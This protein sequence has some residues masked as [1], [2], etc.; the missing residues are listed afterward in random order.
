[1]AQIIAAILGSQLVLWVV[2][3]FVTRHYRKKDNNDLVKTTLSVLTYNRLADKIE[4][5]LT[6]GYATPDERREIKLLEDVYKS[7]G[8]NGDMESRL[9]KVYALRTNAPR[10]KGGEKHDEKMVEGCRRESYKN[11]SSDCCCHDWNNG[12]DFRG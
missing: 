5:C 11:Y 12:S 6:K 10:E 7:W 9:D 2:Q 1:M 4:Y 3:V 8:W